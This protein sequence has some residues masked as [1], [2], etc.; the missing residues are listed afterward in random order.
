MPGSDTDPPGGGKD[1]P[2][3]GDP[4]DP[5]GPSGDTSP[6][7]VGDYYP[8]GQEPTGP[9]KEVT[10]KDGDRT[11]TVG[12]PN[13]Q[14][15]SK[16]TVDDGKGEKKSYNVDFNGKP[17]PGEKPTGEDEDVIYADEDG[18]AVIKDGDATIT[19]G[20]VPGDPGH[21]TM[22]VDDGTPT[23]YDLDF[24]ADEPDGSNVDDIPGPGDVS[25]PDG[26]S[27]SSSGGGGGAGGG[28]GGGGGGGVGGDIASPGGG[29]GAGAGG[30]PS[31]GSMMGAGAAP[32]AE[33]RGGAGVPAAASAGGGQQGGAMGGGGMPMGGMG[34][35]G[36]QGGD[37]QR[38]SKWRTTG[39]LFDEEDPAANFSGVVGRDPGEKPAKPPKR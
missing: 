24:D 4:G 35:G 16:V 34:A 30:A 17:K 27:A 6:S 14:G 32:D 3:I 15:V 25:M 18:K 13:A 38:Q 1:V 19:L 10:I 8:P 37:Q 5:G 26:S 33:G 21:L 2:D 11:I 28:I 23:D 9:P 31:P 20:E 7:N 39:Q 29:A 12:Q 22:N 36:G